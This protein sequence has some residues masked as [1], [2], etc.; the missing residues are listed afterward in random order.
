MKAN[1]DYTFG[2]ASLEIV[3]LLLGAFL[4]GMLLC[5]LLRKLGLCCRAQQ[6]DIRQTPSSTPRVTAAQTPSDRATP[7]TGGRKP[8]EFPD[9]ASG[10][11]TAD[12]NTLL[13][14]RDEPP[15]VATVDITTASTASTLTAT[16]TASSTTRKDDL[17]KLEGIG[18]KLEK[19]L[20]AAGIQSYAQLAAM[21]PEQIRPILEAA[22]SQFKMHDPK[23]WPYQAELAAKG[24]WARLKEYQHLLITGKE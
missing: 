9:V 15:P 14:K 18:P 24:D 8:R 23:S 20:N 21:T 1:P 2:I 7:L 16:T 6:H 4:L 19:I 13:R 3:L 11:F 22:G 10:G 5:W 12:I 17:K